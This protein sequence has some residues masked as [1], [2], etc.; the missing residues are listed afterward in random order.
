MF[1]IDKLKIS[2]K[3]GLIVILLAVVGAGTAGFA[4]WRMMSGTDAYAYLVRHV[5]R[6][7]IMTVRAGR[8]V[9]QYIS[10]A[11]LLAA[12]NSEDGKARTAAEIADDKAQFDT[13]IAQVRQDLPEKAAFIDNVIADSHKAFSV[14]EVSLKQAAATRSVEELVKATERI[15][16]E[17]EPS[18]KVGVQNVIKLV[19][20]LT[21]FAG[22]SSDELV[23]KTHD[24]VVTLLAAVAGGLVLA[25]TAAWWIGVR[26]LSRPLTRLKAVME[27]LARHELEIEVPG[28][29]RRDEL[30]EM[31]RSVEIFKINAGEVERLR[32]EQEA[33]KRQAATA[34]KQAMNRM[35]DNFEARVLEVVEIVSSSSG[36]LQAT[37]ETMSATAS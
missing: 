31:A 18:A 2:V 7:T 3:I 4:A 24:T 25:L 19:N 23:A 12:D 9:A 10:S 1:N 8:F 22:Q 26:N 29:G 20:D 35:A 6:S 32:L 27:A 33:Q 16:V 5:D 11:Y 37:A 28:L 34:Q 14:C 17:C 36:E 15:K 21:A 13:L 30:G